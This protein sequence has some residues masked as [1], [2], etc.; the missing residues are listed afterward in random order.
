MM[1]GRF[2]GNTSDNCVVADPI[3]QAA[4]VPAIG[5]RAKRSLAAVNR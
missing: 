4:G 1:S 3:S 5:S 2:S